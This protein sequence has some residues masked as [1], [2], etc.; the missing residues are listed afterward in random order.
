MA[1]LD[2]LKAEEQRLLVAKE[3]AETELLLQAT[4]LLDVAEEEHRRL[5]AERGECS[6]AFLSRALLS[7]CS[8]F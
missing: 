6:A 1:D 4:S 3:A 8:G 7:F 2:S 5:T